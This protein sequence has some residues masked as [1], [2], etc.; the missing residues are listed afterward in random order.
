MTT[1]DLDTSPVNKINVNDCAAADYDSV[2]DVD[3]LEKAHKTK[4]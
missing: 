3:R 2:M 4:A 1:T